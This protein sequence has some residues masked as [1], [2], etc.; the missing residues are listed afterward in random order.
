[1]MTVKKDS[2]GKVRDYR[3]EYD[4]YHAKPEQKANRAARNGARE[5]IRGPYEV[6]TGK[7]LPT[8]LEVDHKRPIHQGGDSG[9][10]NLALV[11]RSENRSKG[12]SRTPAPST[13]Q[14]GFM[15]PPAPAQTQLNP[16]DHQLAL[17]ILRKYGYA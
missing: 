14:F 15:K 12:A 16:L 1:M 6:A 7:P 17:E 9:M 8:E 3:K 13:Y 2:S 11:P 10:A 5:A 4:N